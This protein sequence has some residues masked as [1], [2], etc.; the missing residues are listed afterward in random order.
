MYPFRRSTG[1]FPLKDGVKTTNTNYTA[2][3]N[4]RIQ[5]T[6]NQVIENGTLLIQNG[7]V[8]ATGTSVSIPQNTVVIDLKGKYIYP[9][10]IDMYSEFGVE[11]PKLPWVETFCPVC[12][13]REGFYGMIHVMPEKNAMDCI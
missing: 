4:A 11:K 6:P 1:L 3:T 10:F 13:T 9:S 5:V 7:K 12:A 2:F 8:V